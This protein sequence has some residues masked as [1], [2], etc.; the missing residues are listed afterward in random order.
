MN[1]RARTERHEHRALAGG[2]EVVDLGVELVVLA[3]PAS[4]SIHR[5][6]KRLRKSDPAGTYDY[7]HLYL[8]GG[9]VAEGP[10]TEGAQST[11]ASALSAGFTSG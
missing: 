11:A 5:A 8:G 2:Q 1:A 6:L 10:T 7:N 9:R 3:V 4:T